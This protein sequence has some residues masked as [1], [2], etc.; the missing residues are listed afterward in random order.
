M[1]LL[2]DARSGTHTRLDFAMDR[3]TMN[4]H[5]NATSHINALC[6]VMFDSKLYDDVPVGVIAPDQRYLALD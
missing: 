1:S 4:V 6:H 3:F 2:P 5:G